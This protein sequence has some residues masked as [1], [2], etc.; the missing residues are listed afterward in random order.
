MSGETKDETKDGSE[1]TAV[2]LRTVLFL[3]SAK[4]VSP[5]WGGEK[6]LGDRVYKYIA[7]TLAS[8][9]QKIGNVVVKHQVTVYDPLTV[10]G[11]GGALETSGAHVQA[12][13]FF[14]QNEAI[15]T[16]MAEMMDT[17]KRADCFVIATAEYNHSP[18]PALVAMLDH[19]GGACYGGKPS[20]IVSYSMGPFGG[21]R[22]AMT[23]QPLLHELGC[24][25]VSKMTHL[26]EP[27]K[28]FD[29]NG[30]PLDEKNRALSQLPGTLTHLEWM[31][32]A[33]KSQRALAPEVFG[34]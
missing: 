24:L 33:M 7:N 23:L 26:G 13:S 14:L 4:N 15:P 2:T 25:P 30:V 9:A 11:P 34:E 5:P 27:A 29:E 8:R 28:L 12:P 17:I 18:A 6:R 19:F 21:C 22:A 31:A 20:A 3:G 10:F 32:L 1:G 16:G